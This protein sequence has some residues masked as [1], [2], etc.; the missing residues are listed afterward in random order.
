MAEEQEDAAAAPGILDDLCAL[1]GRSEFEGY[2]KP[3][4]R[5]LHLANLVREQ[6]RELRRIENR[7]QQLELRIES[8]KAVAD[9]ALTIDH[10]G[11]IVEL[12]GRVAEL[13]NQLARGSTEEE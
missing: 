13:Q 7:N 11:E 3:R 4:E 10:L 2:T 6:H 1:F 8:L 5:W 9:G 12:K